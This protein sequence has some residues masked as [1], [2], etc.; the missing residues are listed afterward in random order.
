[1]ID[2]EKA[3]QM[4]S[5]ICNS[6]NCFKWEYRFY[7]HKK[8]NKTTEEQQISLDI[9]EQEKALHSLLTRI[10]NVHTLTN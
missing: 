6:F 8:V 3:R 7:L 9:M 5:N 2:S 10:E 1:M 4:L